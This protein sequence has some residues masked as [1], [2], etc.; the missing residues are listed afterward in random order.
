MKG[1]RENKARRPERAAVVMT[2]DFGRDSF[3]VGAMKAAAL[4]VDPRA[5]IID[6][7]HGVRPFAVD[8]ASF[9]LSL[10]F[11]VWK[12]GTVF[13]TV[14]DPDVG[15]NRQNIIVESSRRYFV[16]PDNGLVSDIVERFGTGAVF[17]IAEDEIER[18]RVSRASGRTFLGRD[19][20]APAA[21]FLARGGDPGKIG[22]P[23]QAFRRLS[24]PEVEVREGRVRGQAR[25]VDDFG[26]VLTNIAGRDLTRAFGDTAFDAM[27]VN[28]GGREILGVVDYFSRGA[29]GELLAILDSWDL[30]ELSVNRGRAVDRFAPG[31]PV[32]VE[33]TRR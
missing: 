12:E 23:V 26:N 14:V 28:V 10:V 1:M 27:R 3:Y 8:E 6:L 30:I 25:Y 29:P 31:E 33:I 11:D 9:I 32:I 17:A 2:T 5:L 22:K 4:A 13:L 20:F 16:G 7:T 24:L 21:A 19:V 18:F 15:G